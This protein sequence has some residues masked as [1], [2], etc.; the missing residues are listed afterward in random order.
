MTLKG[1][2]SAVLVKI[3]FKF[4]LS[5]Q[6]GSKGQQRG[7]QLLKTTQHLLLF[8]A[9]FLSCDKDAEC[10]YVC[11]IS[12]ILAQQRHG[13][14]LE[15][16]FLHQGRFSVRGNKKKNWPWN[17]LGGKGAKQAYSVGG[18]CW[19]ECKAITIIFFGLCPS[20]QPYG[21]KM[22]DD[23]RQQKKPIR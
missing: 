21:K 1:C 7:A 20:Q 8:R 10:M 13:T 19:S 14:T 5:C 17:C 9:L 16:L 4:L 18:F 6:I 11:S 22:A 15:A 23:W 3:P 12:F 2:G